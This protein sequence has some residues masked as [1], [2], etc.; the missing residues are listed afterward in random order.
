VR[1]RFFL[2]EA[3]DPALRISVLLPWAPDDAV[4]SER[5]HTHDLVAFQLREL[6]PAVTG[7]SIRQGEHTL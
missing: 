2:D 7:S 3:V 6:K 5:R 4:I 1:D